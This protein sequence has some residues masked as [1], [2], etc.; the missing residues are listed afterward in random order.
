M[1]TSAASIQAGWRVTALI[2]G[3]LLAS[4]VL[5][6]LAGLVLG[7]LNVLAL[8]RFGLELWLCWQVYQGKAWA[9]LVLCLLLLGAG[10]QMLLGGAVLFGLLPILFALALFFT[11]QVN[12]YMDYAAQQ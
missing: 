10:V 12:A 6:L 4:S 9:R 1:T 5:G 3:L 8:A 7:T 11:P 2:L